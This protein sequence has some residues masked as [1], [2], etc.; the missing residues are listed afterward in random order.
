MFKHILVPTD[1][2]D[3][4]K[5]TARKAVDFAKSI[6]AEITAYHAKPEM[7]SA[8]FYGEIS[9]TDASTR[10]QFKRLVDSEA[11]KDLGYI[12]AL[13]REAGVP[14]HAIATPTDTPYEG[15]LDA[16]A[17]SGADLIFMASHGRKGFKARLIGSETQRVL[18]QS[19]IPVLVYRWGS[20][21]G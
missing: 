9:L 19:T 1:G 13:C 20:G 14:C 18:T 7:S 12:E 4:S 11:Q 17:E 2:S 5:E 6:G 21:S 8:T 15:I 10:E 3:L 16:A